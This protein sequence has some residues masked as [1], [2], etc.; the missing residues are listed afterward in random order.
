MV[1]IKTGNVI[2][3]TAQINCIDLDTSAG[4]KLAIHLPGEIIN[5]AGH[6]AIDLLMRI[7]PSALEGAQLKY[8]KN[9]WAFHNLVAHPLLQLCSWFGFHKLGFM[10]HDHTAP[11][12]KCT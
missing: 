11:E 5:M 8:A 3:D 7:C 10:I 4:V 2:L 9:A 12:P 6:Q 1:F